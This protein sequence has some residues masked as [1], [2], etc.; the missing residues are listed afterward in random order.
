MV[1]FHTSFQFCGGDPDFLIFR[2]QLRM[3]TQGCD[4]YI[5]VHTSII[6]EGCNLVLVDN[7]SL[8]DVRAKF[9]SDG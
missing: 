4:W 9:S 6:I 7:P 8:A 2:R 3:V 5:T 1:S